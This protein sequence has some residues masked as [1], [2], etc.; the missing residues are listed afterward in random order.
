LAFFQR[1]IVAL[2]IIKEKESKKIMP[3]LKVYPPLTAAKIHLWKKA[4]QPAQVEFYYGRVYCILNL[5]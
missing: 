2:G 4:K 1:C 5:I 3:H